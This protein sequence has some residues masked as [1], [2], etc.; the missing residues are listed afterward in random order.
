MPEVKIR[1]AVATDIPMLMAINHSG[2]SEY[3]WQMDIQR[4]DG[5]AGAIF[6]E[7]CLPRAVVVHYPRPVETMADEWSR[8]TS[9]LV[10]LLGESPVG[11][12]RLTDK[13]VP[14]TAWITDLA[15]SPAARRKG[16]ASAL[17]LAAQGW[18]IQRKDHRAMLE[19]SSK[20]NPAIRL[21]QKLGYEFCGYND[22]YYLNKDIALFFGRM[23]K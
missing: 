5:Q 4:E 22:Q 18:A 13:L 10:A 1:P 12:L 11:Y 14:Q 19:M 23:L 9:M 17:V 20:N 21:A 7:I 15:V 6:R 3:V 2:T 8:R 16:I